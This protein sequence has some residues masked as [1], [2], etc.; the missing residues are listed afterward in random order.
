VYSGRDARVLRVDGA[1]PRT[2]VAAAQR[3]VSDGDAALTAVTST[4]LDPRRVAVTERRVPGVPE[5]DDG[6]PGGSARIVSYAPDRVVIDA[7]LTRPGL[8][9]LGDNWFPGW[10]ATVDGRA[11]DVERVDYVFRAAAAGPG[12]HRVEFTYRPASWRIGWIVSLLTLA[13]LV[14]AVAL[15]LRRAGGAGRRR[16]AARAS[17][18]PA[19]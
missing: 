5:H 3:P 18:A 19:R 4:G 2:F 6:A 7:R 16:S 1:L 10:K 9:V 11:A 15:S 14:V 17:A 8:V 12:L 13:A